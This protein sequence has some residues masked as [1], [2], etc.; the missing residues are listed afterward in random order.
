MPVPPRPRRRPRGFTLVE[1]LV[2]IGIIALL[3]SILLPSLARARQ[4]A[5]QTACL[6]NIRNM[7]TATQMFVNEHDGWMYKAWLNSRP[8][9]ALGDLSSGE[10][11]YDYPAW[12]WDYILSDYMGGNKSVFQCPSDAD[13]P[14]VRGVQFDPQDSSDAPRT[15]NRT[16]AAPAWYLASPDRWE[17][18]NLPAS[19]RYNASNIPWPNGSAKI[20]QIPNVSESILIAEGV[21]DTFH[22]MATWEPFRGGPPPDVATTQNPYNEGT[23]YQGA[24]QRLVPVGRHVKDNLSYMFFDGHGETLG[25]EETWRPL[26]ASFV[27]SATFGGTKTVTPTPWR[28]RYPT[29]GGGNTWND[30]RP[31][32]PNF[33]YP[34][35]YEDN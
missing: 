16:S 15:G 18:D 8:N 27:Y 20:T 17:A 10:W 9:T 32:D 23:A 29:T 19:Y 26:G 33:D 7:G 4:T 13:S 5:Q 34:S 22:H 2:V 3:I 25:W 12:G 21:G 6:S 14:W 24:Y 35:N 11:R 1:L 30:V 28:T 31:Y